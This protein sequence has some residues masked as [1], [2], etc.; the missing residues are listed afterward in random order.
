MYELIDNQIGP[1]GYA[2]FG[3]FKGTSGDLENNT[4]KPRGHCS[5]YVHVFRGLLITNRWIQLKKNLKK[6]Q[7]VILPFRSSVVPVSGVVRFE[8]L[9][10]PKMPH[11]YYLLQ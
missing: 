2:K 7:G 1:N 5:A 6:K 10:T 9:K 11:L 3:K 4:N 8:V